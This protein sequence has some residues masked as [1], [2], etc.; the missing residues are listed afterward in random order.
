MKAHRNTKEGEGKVDYVEIEQLGEFKEKFEYDI[1]SERA[2]LMWVEVETWKEETRARAKDIGDHM[3]DS[4]R[5]R[6]D[7]EQV[8]VYEYV[9]YLMNFMKDR[10]KTFDVLLDYVEENK[11]EYIGIHHLDRL[12][13]E[14]I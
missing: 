10:P 4:T 9:R 8:V 11:G 13:R 14:K 6:S 5:A 12:A 2:L 3:L 7:R 1:L